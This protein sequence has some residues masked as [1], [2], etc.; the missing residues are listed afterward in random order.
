MPPDA[1]YRLPQGVPPAVLVIWMGSLVLVEYD[2]HPL[3]RVLRIMQIPVVAG[4]PGHDRHVIGIRG[5]D[6]GKDA[7]AFFT[8]LCG[9]LHVSDPLIQLL[10]LRPLKYRVSDIQVRYLHTL[11]DSLLQIWGSPLFTAAVFLL[12]FSSPPSATP[13][14][15]GKKGQPQWIS[16]TTALILMLI[17]WLPAV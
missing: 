14:P 6:G 10:Y 12:F 11:D 3:I 8:S 17:D 1:P 2:H 15:A 7:V 5:Y 13:A 16:G 4:V 9:S